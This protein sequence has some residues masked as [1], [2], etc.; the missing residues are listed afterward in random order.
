MSKQV[1]Q[2]TD[3]TPEFIHE[4]KVRVKKKLNKS[5]LEIKQHVN[6]LFAPPKNDTRAERI[7][8]AIDRSIAIF[9][10]VMFGMKIVR[11]FQHF[12]LKKK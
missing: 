6:N 10:G 7:S 11:Q 8:S 5:S 9:D 4:Q 3:Y 1:T 2:S 12:F